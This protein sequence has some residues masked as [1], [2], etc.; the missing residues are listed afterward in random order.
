VDDNHGTTVKKWNEDHKGDED[1]I[2]HGDD[3]FICARCLRSMMP[4]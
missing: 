1:A 3:G 4:K 2:L